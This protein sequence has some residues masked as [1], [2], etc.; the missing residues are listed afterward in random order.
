MYVCNFSGGMHFLKY[1]DYNIKNFNATASVYE[2]MNN[3][4]MQVIYQRLV[5]T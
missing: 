2:L 4:I 5:L 3:K 1:C